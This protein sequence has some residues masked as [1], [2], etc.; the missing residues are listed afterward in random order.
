[1]QLADLRIFTEPQQ[2][3]TYGTLL[4]MATRA[5]ALGFGA[6]FRSDHYLAMGGSDGLPGPTDAWIT[7]AG[8]A[9]E[10][11]TIRLGTLVSPVTFRSPGLLAISVAQVDEMSGGR[12][13]LG[14]GAG[15]YEAE[16]HAYALDF[17][18]T[19]GRFDMLTDQLAIIDGLW[20]TPIGETFSYEGPV[21]SVVE[22]PGLP[23]PAQA[24]LPIVMGG[25]GRNKTPRLA[26]RYASE[27]NLPFVP[28]ETF[29]R[30]RE[31]VRT[32]CDDIARTDPM[33]FSV[34][35]V[36]CAGSD[37]AEVGRRAA[38][39]GREPAELRLNGAAGTPAEVA[40]TIRRYHDAGA[41]RVYLQVLDLHDLEH[42]DLIAGEVAPLLA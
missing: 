25:A 39:I 37:E 38:A 2:G 13:E 29:G 40:D 23:K 22:S 26:A 28:V 31:R 32:A 33:T 36:V 15:W 20:K 8:L 18:S 7:L 30:Q 6:F 42:L 10:T 17:P 21:H 24:R 19:A 34:A 1:M 27:F 41:D 14:I 11:S 16:H 12:V 35:L 3:A 5:E 9:R 4:A